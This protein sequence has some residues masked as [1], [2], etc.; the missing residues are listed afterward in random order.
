MADEGDPADLR[1]EVAAFYSGFGQPELL[2][3]AFRR[4]ALYV[5][6]TEDDRVS[7]CAVGG[8]RWLC[9][10]TD[11]AELAGWLSQRGVHPDGE[12]R[13][14]TLL[15]W[16]LAD[17]AGAQSD[18]TGVLV[19]AAGAAPIAFPPAVDED[20]VAVGMGTAAAGPAG[21]DAAGAV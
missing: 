15:G 20:G 7:T 14:H 2:L 6:L 5:P 17:Y 3:A 12:Y 19:D 18:P 21:E 9:A 8:V 4:A 1:S 11:V 13:Y 16:R 10:F